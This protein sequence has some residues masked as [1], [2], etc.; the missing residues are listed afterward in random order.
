[1]F[2]VCYTAYGVSDASQKRIIKKIN[3]YI[4]IY[5]IGYEMRNRARHRLRE[6]EI[7]CMKLWKENTCIWNAELKIIDI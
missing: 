5:I 2:N 3:E 4:H 6:N 7:M 1:M